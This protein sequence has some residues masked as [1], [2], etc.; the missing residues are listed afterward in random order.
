[1]LIFL[2]YFLLLNVFLRKEYQLSRP[3]EKMNGFF[4][5]TCSKS[6]FQVNHKKSG[7]G[8]KSPWPDLVEYRLNKL[9]RMLIAPESFL[10]KPDY[11]I[12]LSRCKCLYLQHLNPIAVQTNHFC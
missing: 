8:K 7:H 12:Q 9:N 1:M 3:I 2:K 6:S 11:Q 4:G 5:K 10:C